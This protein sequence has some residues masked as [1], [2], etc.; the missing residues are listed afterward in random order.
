MGYTICLC[1]FETKFKVDFKN[2]LSRT[3]IRYRTYPQSL[4]GICPHSNS[5][6]VTNMVH[7]LFSVGCVCFEEIFECISNGVLSLV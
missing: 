5:L 4:V 1:R 7:N 2:R 3:N 6:N